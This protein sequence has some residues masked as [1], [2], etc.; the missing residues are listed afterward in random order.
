VNTI[1]SSVR[2][3]RLARSHASSN[4]LV[5]LPEAKA[6]NGTRVSP[7]RAG[8]SASHVYGRPSLRRRRGLAAFAIVPRHAARYEG[9]GGYVLL[10]GINQFVATAGPIRRHR[11]ATRM[12]V[13][14]GAVFNDHNP[15]WMV[16]PDVMGYFTRMSYLLRQG[17]P[18]YDVAVLLPEEDAQARFRPGHVSVTDE[19]EVCS[20]R[21][22]CPRFSM[23]VTIRLH[24]FG[25]ARQ[26]WHA[27]LSGAGDSNV[28]R[29]PL[30]TYRCIEGL[31]S[32]AAS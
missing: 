31:R 11:L 25:G 12:V 8:T 30:A 29:L 18:V 14:R 9:R 27:V 32:V 7:S 15:W 26:S 20:G 28:E 22:W 17:S 24:R 21:I 10:Q 19:Y 1:Q 13:L 23:R 5:D 4:S 3:L 2:K 16:M 6:H